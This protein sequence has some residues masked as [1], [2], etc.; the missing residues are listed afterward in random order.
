MQLTMSPGLYAVA[1]RPDDPGQLRAAVSLACRWWGGIRFPWLPLG[2]DGSVREDAE[3]LCDVLDVAGIIDL[4]RSDTGEPVPAGLEPLGLTVVAGDHRPPWGMPVRAV[5]TSATEDPLVMAGEVGSTDFDPAALLGLGGLD[6]SERA[7]WEEAGQSVSVAPVGSCLLPQLEG[8]T[9]V[10]VTATAVDNFISTTAFMTSAALVW[11]LPDSFTLAEVARDLAGFW[12]YRALRLRHRGTVTVLARLSSLR[13]EETRRR[14]VEAVSATALST[15]MCV[16]NGLA[17]NDDD[18][19]AA[20]EALGFRVISANTKWAERHYQPEDAPELTAVIDHPLAGWWLGDRYTGTSRDILAVARRPRWQARIESPLPWRYPEALQGLVS[21]RITSPVI[22]GPPTDTVAALYQSNAR[23]RSGGVRIFTRATPTYHLD[24]GMPQPAEVLAAALADRGLRFVVSDKGREID[25]ILAASDDLGLVRRPAFH[26]VTAALT[27]QPSP[28][29]DH[30]LER[31]ADQIAQ[32]PEIATAAEELRDVTA[33]A[34]AKPLTLIELASHPTVRDRGLSRAD[35][36]AVLADMVARGLARWG[37]ERHCDLCGLTELVPLTAAAAVPQCA[38]CGRDAAY[39]TRGGEPVL[40]Y[41]LGSLLQRVSR[42]SGLTPLAAAAAFRQQGY[43]IIPGATI[44]QA[45]CDRE[46]DLLGWKDYRLLAGEAKAAASLF[47]A[48]G[49][50]Q[51][52][53]WAASIGAISYVITCPET[54]PTPLV[55]GAV[56]AADEHDV[57]LLQITGPALTSGAPPTH[58]VLQVAAAEGAS[59]QAATKP[60]GESAGPGDDLPPSLAT[61][62]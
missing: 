57:E 44:P 37:F 50:A 27:P 35:L 17:V 61:L 24:I 11:L 3:R 39:T 45:E 59:R 54:L 10:G 29:I 49:I 26:A 43:Y 38:G 41:A 31:L 6:E 56:Q 9:A 15:P 13:Q 34:R 7:G 36:S 46:T 42:N 30:A 51:D 48:D 62:T 1:L 21:A 4:T 20:A 40:H 55:E 5:V 28:R 14:L 47:T 52:I 53:G 58:A 22:T 2:L 18:L 32:D 12:N 23:W 33:R 8:R 16:F 60:A 19:R 25:G